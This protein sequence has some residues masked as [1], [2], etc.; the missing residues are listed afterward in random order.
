MDQQAALEAALTLFEATLAGEQLIHDV[1][2]LENGLT[3]SF[4]QFL[5][6][7]EIIGWIKAYLPGLE[8][9][10]ETLALDVIEEAAEGKEFMTSENTVRHFRDDWYPELLDRADHATWI[11]A[12]AKTLREKARSKVDEL[13]ASFEAPPIPA[14]VR[15]AWTEI[16]ESPG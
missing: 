8:I 13:L 11:A 16:I 4:E 1:G 10:Q 7:H 6:C 15:R 12:D 3:G 9:T 5:I 2:Y 14:D